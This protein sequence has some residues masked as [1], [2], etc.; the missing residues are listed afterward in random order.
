MK[1]LEKYL[2][3]QNSFDNLTRNQLAAAI[4]YIDTNLKNETDSYQVIRY[5]ALKVDLVNRLMILDENKDFI[6]Y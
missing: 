5:C 1:Y 4:I 6:I 2:F 3:Q